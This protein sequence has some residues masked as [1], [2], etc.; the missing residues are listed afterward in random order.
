MSELAQRA[1][2]K[3]KVKRGNFDIN[4]NIHPTNASVKYFRGRFLTAKPG[5]I[6]TN[7]FPRFPSLE[8]IRKNGAYD[9]MAELTGEKRITMCLQVK[10]KFGR[11]GSRRHAERQGRLG[12]TGINA[13]SIRSNL[14]CAW[15]VERWAGVEMI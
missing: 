14:T 7:F 9:T 12:Q 3:S 2:C 10:E 5:P 15:R 1:V 6:P 13:S 11:I 8:S 4:S